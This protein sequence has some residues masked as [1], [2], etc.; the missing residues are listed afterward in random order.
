MSA[1]L[2]ATKR[3]D[4]MPLLV[5][6]APQM[7]SRWLTDKEVAR[8]CTWTPN[9][10]M[11]QAVSYVE[12]EVERDKRDDYFAWGMYFDSYKKNS[13]HPQ[14]FG[15]ITLAVN[16]KTS[17]GSVE[18]VVMRPEWNKGYATEAVAKVVEFALHNLALRRVIA[19]CN[20]ECIAAQHVLENVGMKRLYEFHMPWKTKEGCNMVRYQVTRE[21]Y[22]GE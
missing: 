7:Y 1:P 14:I 18:F 11:E 3:F 9:R 16:T 21:Q 20:V 13:Y 4:L 22:F 15:Q 12:S 8:F 6:N 10:S 5:R 2:L 19:T 17:T